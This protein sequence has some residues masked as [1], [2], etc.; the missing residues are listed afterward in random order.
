MIRVS[1]DEHVWAESYNRKLDD[2][3]GV[4]GEVAGAIADQLNAKLA[5]TEQK[6]VADKPTQNAAA[7]DAYLRGLSLEHDESGFDASRQAARDYVEAVQ[8]D[9][10]GALA[11]YQEALKRLPN[12]SFVYQYLG[13]VQCRLGQWKE[14]EV[15]YKKALEL[16]P[17]DVSLLDTMGLEFYGALRRFDDAHAV[18]DRALQIAP[19]SAASR[20]NKASLFQSD[21][22]LE[23]AA[24]EL[25]RIPEDVTDDSAVDVRLVQAMFERHYDTAIKVIERKF[26]SI[27]VGQPVDPLL[28]VSL[29][30]CHELIGQP[31]EAGKAFTRAVQA[32]KSTL[33]T[34]VGRNVGASGNLADAYAGLGEK[35]KA[36][37]W[38][39]RAVK[40]CEDDALSK[41]G[42]E[43]VLAQI[44]ARF[45]D[46]D[47][48]IAALP[49]LLEVP[50]GIT[51]ADLKINPFWDPLRNDPRFQK[52]AA[53]EA[54]KQ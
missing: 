50:A 30:F 41:P 32:I 24:R 37:E 48:A 7:Y 9:F 6:A 19:D 22:R 31:E 18:V 33:E 17:R 10:K 1:N 4:E 40:E 49:H 23:E 16:D 29:G 44:Q 8:L 5:G 13:L 36:L 12:N 38:A 27:P 53:S 2:V 15:N 52:L 3:F 39:K 54:S 47:A 35:E 21:G 51:A 28:L 46:H 11:S 34:V 25:A 42:A 45:G 20:A 14:A 43:T 26:N